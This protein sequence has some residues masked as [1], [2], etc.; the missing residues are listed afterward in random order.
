MIV[1]KIPK[2]FQKTIDKTVS[3]VYNIEV[4]GK[5]QRQYAGVAEL[6]DA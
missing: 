2:N 3:F 6:A 5:T 4:A 1:K